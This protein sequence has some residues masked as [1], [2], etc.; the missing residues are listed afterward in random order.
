MY[1]LMRDAFRRYRRCT[2]LRNDSVDLVE[3]DRHLQ[4]RQMA[5]YRYH[6]PHAAATAHNLEIQRLHLRVRR[7]AVDAERQK[8]GC[9]TPLGVYW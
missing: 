9:G 7:R 3:Q 4:A 2:Q 1:D 6:A 5:A 8:L